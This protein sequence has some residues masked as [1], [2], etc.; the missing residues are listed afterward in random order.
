LYN[1][2]DNKIVKNFP[3]KQ[4]ISKICYFLKP[5]CMVEYAKFVWANIVSSTGVYELPKNKR[6]AKLFV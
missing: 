6:K 5:E 2:S 4:K 1:I 3:L